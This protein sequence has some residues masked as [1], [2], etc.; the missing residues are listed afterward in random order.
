MIQTGNFLPQEAIV[1]RYFSGQGGLDR[2]PILLGKSGLGSS[3]TMARTASLTSDQ[4]IFGS[5]LHQQLS[6]EN[7]MFCSYLQGLSRVDLDFGL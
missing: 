4:I 1:G 2:V 3:L 6:G 5:S 7:T